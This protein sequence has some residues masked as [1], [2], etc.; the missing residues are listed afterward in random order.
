MR[1]TPNEVTRT[2]EDILSRP[3]FHRDKTWLQ[4]FLDWLSRHLHLGDNGPGTSGGFSGGFGGLF[5]W[6]IVVLLC[7][8]LLVI[9]WRVIRGR[10]RRTKV[11]DSEPEIEIEEIRT[12]RQW[13]D[14]AAE[15]E[16]AG[17]WKEAIRCRYR[18][19]VG[20][21]ID[22]RAVSDVP[23]RTTG[24][25]RAELT[26]TTPAAASDFDEASW[27]FEL[28]WYAD[29]PTGPEESGHFAELARNVLDSTVEHRLDVEQVMSA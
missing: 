5:G 24:E 9:A 26:T 29:A 8:V 2:A 12:T 23:G 20:R 15:L 16:A 21:L 7:A 28:P 14:A 1:P 10:V 18:E 13:A 4:R 11:H 3:E 19:L 6:I 25:L 22:R 17:E 27:L